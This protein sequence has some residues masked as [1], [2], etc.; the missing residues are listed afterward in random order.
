MKRDCAS[1]RLKLPNQH[2]P[3]MELT[4][5]EMLVAYKYRDEI[6]KATNVDLVLMIGEKE[7]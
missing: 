7:I 4:A 3:N 1:R 6:E 5:E 2:L